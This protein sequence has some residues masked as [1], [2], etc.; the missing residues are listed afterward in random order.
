MPYHAM[1]HTTIP[2][3]GNLGESTVQGFN[4]GKGLAFATDDRL[5]ILAE[6]T[7]VCNRALKLIN[8]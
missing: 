5:H 1:L 2:C 3:T 4:M 7:T 8:I 6:Q